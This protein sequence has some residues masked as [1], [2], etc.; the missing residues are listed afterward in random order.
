MKGG[1]FLESYR[2]C[3]PVSLS[4]TSPQI[5]SAFVVRT[6]GKLPCRPGS[7]LL[8]RCS[9]KAMDLFF[10]IKVGNIFRVMVLFFWLTSSLD[11]GQNW[12]L[13]KRA[14]RGR[15][16]YSCQVAMTNGFAAGH[17][18]AQ[19]LAAALKSPVRQET[20]CYVS[21]A[22]PC[23][24]Q[25]FSMQSWWGFLARCHPRCCELFGLHMCRRFFKKYIFL[26]MLSCE[27]ITWMC[28]NFI[29]FLSFHAYFRYFLLV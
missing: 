13:T 12:H 10:K 21:G 27:H 7:S 8:K 9:F 15:K 1:P 4:P 14:L 6:Q 29:S 26:V 16:G 17:L 11:K 19:G 25:H 3:K 24:G 2:H 28:P 22:H 20:E 18:W 23:K 5:D